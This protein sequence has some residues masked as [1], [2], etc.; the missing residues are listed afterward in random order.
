MIKIS[1]YDD[2]LELVEIEFRFIRFAVE[3]LPKTKKLNFFSTISQERLKRFDAGLKK[4][5]VGMAPEEIEELKS[6]V[7]RRNRKRFAPRNQRIFAETIQDGTNASE[8]LIRVA[9]FESFMKDIHAEVLRARP[10][11]LAKIRPEQSVKYKD[12]FVATS[13]ATIL[14]QQIFREVDEMDRLSFRRRAEYFD[15][16]LN[17]PMADEETLQFVES[18]METRNEVAHENPLKTIST[19]DLKKAATTFR[20]IP[21]RVC[22]KAAEIYGKN[23]F[24]F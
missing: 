14:N 2:R 1:S 11:L 3:V 18:I 7:Q 4:L 13:F 6:F 9:L 23:H 17:L 5:P 22:S 21:S 10:T 16:Q 8:L 15:K 24:S 19:N 12:I 20:Q